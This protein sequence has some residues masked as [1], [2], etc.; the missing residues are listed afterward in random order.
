[1]SCWFLSLRSLETLKWS[2]NTFICYKIINTV[3]GIVITEISCFMLGTLFI[4]RKC[5]EFP[6]S[7]VVLWKLHKEI[8]DVNFCYSK[9][10]KV[11]GPHFKGGGAVTPQKFKHCRARNIW[12]KEQSYVF[13]KG[14]CFLRKWQINQS[15]TRLPHLMLP[16]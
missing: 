10:Y 1:M 13:W 4:W 8:V 5:C 6:L 12:A 7:K 14:F 11:M 16:S 9:P 2:K 15:W 3:Y